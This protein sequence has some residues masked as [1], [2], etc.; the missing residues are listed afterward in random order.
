MKPIDHFVA[1]IDNISE[2]VGKAFGWM[3]LLLT[4]GEAYEVFVR[5]ALRAPTGWAY[6]MS[7]I[8]YGALFMMAGAYTVS[9]NGHVRG[10][11]IYRLWPPRVQ[12][13]VDLILYL[14][15]FFP[16][17]AAL[18]YAGAGYARESWGY[19]EVA[20]SSPIGV[21]IYMF[22][23]LIPLA[24]ALMII[25]GVAEVTHCIRCIRSGVWP[26]RAV[27]VIE[28][29]KQIVAEMHEG[30]TAEE[31]IEEMEGHPGHPETRK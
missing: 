13:T 9:R 24:G 5:Y 2:T 10:D 3:I 26:K 21:P 31:I 1:F 11:F 14:F 27:D 8:M 23:T 18:L 19:H 20:I 4:F 22:K 29:E 30:K 28:L 6:D 16:G 7:Y 25:Q 15:F 17:M 12:A